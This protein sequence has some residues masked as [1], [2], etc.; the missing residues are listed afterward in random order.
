MNF[1]SIKALMDVDLESLIPNLDSI[2]G[3]LE[4]ILRVAVLAAPFVILIM[5][6]LYLLAPREANHYIGYRFFWGMNS[7]EAWRFM[8]RLAGFLWCAVGVVLL[9]VMFIL[10]KGI[11]E[12]E[13]MDRLWSVVRYILWEMGAIVAACLVVDITMLVMFDHKGQRR[14]LAKAKKAPK[15]E[16]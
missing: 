15:N 7:V 5:G 13:I 11:G 2:M 14:K 3:V 8:Q 16:Q 4:M 10:T 9:I 1:D 12:K 6:I